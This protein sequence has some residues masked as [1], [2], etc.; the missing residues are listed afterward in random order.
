VVQNIDSIK[1]IIIP[2]FKTFPLQTNKRVD[3][4]DF[5]EVVK[6]KEKGN[7]QFLINW[8]RFNAETLITLNSGRFTRILVKYF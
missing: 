4:N 2:I 5:Y 7:T 1:N 6:L 3:F 8:Y